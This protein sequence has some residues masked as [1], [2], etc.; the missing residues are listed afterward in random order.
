MGLIPSRGTPASARNRWGTADGTHQLS[1]LTLVVPEAQPT[2]VGRPAVNGRRPATPRVGAAS[3]SRDPV[4]DGT[5][6]KDRRGMFCATV[7]LEPGLEGPS[8][9]LSVPCSPSPPLRQGYCGPSSPSV[10]RTWR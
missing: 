9:R 7:L 4:R 1:G 2:V 3:P 10:L 6:V 5:G 8:R